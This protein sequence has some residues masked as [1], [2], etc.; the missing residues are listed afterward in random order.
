MPLFIIPL[1]HSNYCPLFLMRE[2]PSANVVEQIFLKLWLLISITL[3]AL[4]ITN[5]DII[6]APQFICSSFH[7]TPSAATF[8]LLTRLRIPKLCIL[9]NH[10]FISPSLSRTRGASFV[11]GTILLFVTYLYAT[12]CALIKY[13]FISY[14]YAVLSTNTCVHDD[15]ITALSSC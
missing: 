3:H 9:I 4:S 1:Y 6:I 11:W 5:R 12:S 8:S 7:I 14:F 15:V 13:S 10:A 2:F